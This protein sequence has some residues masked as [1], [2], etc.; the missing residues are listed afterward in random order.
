MPGTNDTLFTKVYIPSC[1]WGIRMAAA[2]LNGKKLTINHE[3]RN[4]VALYSKTLPL[5]L[6]KGI[7]PADHMPIARHRLLLIK[8]LVPLINAP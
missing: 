4:P 8:F 7:T 6:G 5:A 1:Q 3:N 2:I